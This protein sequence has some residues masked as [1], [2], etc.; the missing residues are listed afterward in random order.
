MVA[1]FDRKA[2][3]IPALVI[4]LAAVILAVQPA[5]AESGRPDQPSEQSARK[6]QPP[7]D[8]PD[9]KASEKSG[10]KEA[11][12]PGEQAGGEKAD[13]AKDKSLRKADGK[14][15][16]KADDQSAEKGAGKPDDPCKPDKMLVDFELR[17]QLC[18]S[19]LKIGLTETTEILG[20]L[21][22][23][24]RQGPIYE[25]LTDLSLSIDL[26][27]TL[28]VRGNIFARAYQIH[29]RGLSANN[30]DNL[31]TASSIE[32]SRTSRLAELWY[33][34]HFDKWRL[35]IGQQIITT[36]FL[37]PESARLFVN[38]TF[39]WPTLP[40]LALP[41][42][43]PGFPL[44]TPAIRLRVDP[45]EGL[46]L[47]LALF[48]G[49]PTGAGVGGSQ[50][51]D[52]SGTAFRTSD[53]A[54]MISEVR[55]NEA[56]SDH[57]GTY[58]F[59]GWWNSERFRDLHLDTSGSSLASLASNGLPQQRGG[60]FSFYGIV[61]QPFG[62]NE[63]DHTSFAAFVRAMGAPGDRNLIDLYLDGGFVY[64]GPFGRADDQ[65]GLALGYARIGGAAQAFDADVTHLTGQSHPV[66]SGEAILEVTYR[67]QL[68]GWLQLQPDFQ[69]VFNP[70]GGIAT[71]NLSTRRVGDEAVVGLRATM[72]F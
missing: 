63:A 67:A 7:S 13:D 59:G 36:E 40:S 35:R 62:F 21:T 44:G 19:G 11:E 60:N 1:F 8:N 43:G 15:D 34:Q 24:L 45:E 49:D 66:R 6:S 70:G 16:E 52:A 61:D 2:G 25:G 39:G 29:G 64:K 28:H 9:S 41:S 48:N 42:G 47:F 72:S 54:F 71:P 68:N 50:L 14:S 22:G 65:V 10:D 51:R 27:P 4:V 33:E 46:T 17:R 69:Y 5:A 23:G 37:N 18:Q 20:N 26:R 58:R 30:L 56:S 32:A 3:G 38:G 55:Y 53:G 57:N 31:N 12:K